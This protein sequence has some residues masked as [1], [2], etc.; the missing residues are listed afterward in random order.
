[1]LLKI[2]QKPCGLVRVPLASL[3][4]R[5]KIDL[6][7]GLGHYVNLQVVGSL[8]VRMLVIKEHVFDKHQA[9]SLS[10]NVEKRAQYPRSKKGF[11]AGSDGAPNSHAHRDS[12]EPEQDWQAS[13][14]VA[15]P[16]GNKATTSLGKESPDD[17]TLDNDLGEV[18]FSEN[19]GEPSR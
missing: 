15:Q 17:I 6:A 19:L 8:Y 1:M 12:L 4:S 3:T 16:N 5:P 9:A 11:E 7:S 14:V 18:P 2:S 13:K 10:S